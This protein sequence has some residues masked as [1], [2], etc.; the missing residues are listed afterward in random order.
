MINKKTVFV[1]SFEEA[2]YYRKTLARKSASPLLGYTVCPFTPW[3]Q[4]QWDLWGDTRKIVSSFERLFLITHLLKEQNLLSFSEGG[5]QLLSRYCGEVFGSTPFMQALEHSEQFEGIQKT[6]IDFFL[7]YQEALSAHGYLEPGQALNLLPADAFLGSFSFAQSFEMPFYLKDFAQQNAEINFETMPS[8]E[9]F[10]SGELVTDLDKGK[11]AEFLF[12]YGQTAETALLETRISAWLCGEATDNQT[13]AA[14]QGTTC[15]HALVDS[16]QISATMQD[17]S[18]TNAPSILIVC[19]KPAKL[20][21]ALSPYFFDN[22]I[23]ATCYATRSFSETLFGKSY[24]ALKRVFFDYSHDALHDYL[25][26][27]YSGASTFDAYQI[28]TLLR[29]EKRFE[30]DEILATVKKIAPHFSYAEELFQ[31]SDASLILDYFSEVAYKLFARDKVRLEEELD[32]I[33]QL[34]S[35][36]ESARALDATVEEITQYCSDLSFSSIA[37]TNNT[38]AEQVV[39]CSYNNLYRVAYK[40]AG[41]KGF[42]NSYSHVLLC[43]LDARYFVQADA[44]APFNSLNGALGITF[45]DHY[46]S[47]YRS[48]INFAQACASQTFACEHIVSLIDGE[49][50]YHVFFF[51]EFLSYYQNDNSKLLYNLDNARCSVFTKGEEDLK[52]NIAV[53]TSQNN[54][55]AKSESFSFA[56]PPQGFLSDEAKKSLL[57]SRWSSA[58]NKQ[59]Y[60]VSPSDIELYLACPYSW[61]VQRRIN[62]QSLDF[63]RGPMEQGNFAHEIFAEFYQVLPEKLGMKRVTQECLPSALSLLSEIFDRKL[64]EQIEDDSAHY[65]LESHV[66]QIEGEKL[67]DAMLKSLVRQAQLF[68]SFIPFASELPIELSDG[69]T[70]AGAPLVGKIDRIDIDEKNKAFVVVDYKGSV[71]KYSAGFDPE[72]GEFELPQKVQALVYAQAL[73]KKFEDKTCKGALYI[74]YSAKED[75]DSVAGSYNPYLYGVDAYASKKSVVDMDFH[76]YLDMVEDALRPYLKQMRQGHIAPNPRDKTACEYCIVKNNCGRRLS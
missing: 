31:E 54:A 64:S 52:E 8:E 67:K 66:D 27:P 38:Q 21:T 16:N 45:E 9:L 10:I 19:A 65:L 58:E 74:S 41:A 30:F 25:K 42:K 70:Y 62:P 18:I 26:S 23:S 60:Y 46:L 44:F 29:S 75:K 73:R 76:T 68:P 40:N 61:F 49:D 7:S 36:Y 33:R 47:K 71:K 24:L 59:K 50:T 3:L 13:L 11:Q 5:A 20:F 56:I 69:I 53:T 43:D 4:E 28:N 6:L 72:K 12:P 57:L 1:S 37:S 51:E 17:T 2:Y 63:E 22:A 39:V 15:D 34:R 35:L 48:L 55:G 14:N 32:A